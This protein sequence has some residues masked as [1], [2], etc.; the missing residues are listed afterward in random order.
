M[1]LS[2]L[3]YSLCLSRSVF[4]SYVM[5]CYYVLSYVGS[6]GVFYSLG[7]GIVDIVFLFF[8]FS[9]RSRHTMCALVTGVQTCALPICS[10]PRAGCRCEAGPVDEPCGRARHRGHQDPGRR[11][12]RTRVASRVCAAT[13]RSRK[14]REPARVHD[15]RAREG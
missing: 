14:R 12:R 13:H 9:S 3:C 7:I 1:V 2:T 11:S 8:F 15:Q 5:S 10:T 4:I 6:E